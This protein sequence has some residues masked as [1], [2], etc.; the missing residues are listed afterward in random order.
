MATRH[1]FAGRVANAALGVMLA[2]AMATAGSAAEAADPAGNATADPP[3][4]RLRTTA[5]SRQLARDE[6]MAMRDAL[7][8]GHPGAIDDENP[9]YRDRL[10]RAYR[11]ALDLVPRVHDDRDAL[12]IADFYAVSLRDGHLGHSN[13]VRPDDPIRTAGW[14]VARAADGRVRVVGVL[15]PWTVALPPPGAELLACDGRPTEALMREDVLPFSSL[16]GNPTIDDALLSQLSVPAMNDLAYRTCTFAM[17]DGTRASFGQRYEPFDDAS[18]QAW[19]DL[20][21]RHAPRVRV[22]GVDRLPDGTL[23]IRAGDF[24]VDAAGAAKVQALLG[25][26]Q[27]AKDVRRIVFDLRG[28]D[29][30]DSRIGEVIFR[31][32]TGGLRYDTRQLDD[33]PRTRAFWRVSPTVIAA[34]A[35]R[36]STFSARLGAGSAP[37]RDEAT[38]LAALQRA[39]AA[40]DRWLADGDGEPQLTP[41]E[42]ARRGARLAARDVPIAVLTDGLCASACLDMVDTVR[43]VPGAVHAGETTAFDSVYIDVGQLPL[44]SGNM[45]T[46]PLKVWRNRLRGND[47]PWVPHV[48]FPVR[49]RPEAEVRAATLAAFAA[50][51]RD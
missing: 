29:G 46:L 23:W 42:L 38:R 51:P 4:P 20:R 27:A 49:D 37:A 40:H 24:Q 10:E 33:L 26:L 28:N 15:S 43:R 6:L 11:V 31:A 34:V 25:E 41:A 35:R 50:T 2:T 14:R 13:D 8:A 45:L 3:A 30:G 17:A 16:L 9:T 48:P 44:P 47:A 39:L 1:P 12:A 21:P 18:W 22:N 5:Q 32:A 36:E 19:M 7:M